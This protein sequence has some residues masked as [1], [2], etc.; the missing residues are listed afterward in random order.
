MSLRVV[1]EQRADNLPLRERGSWAEHLTERNPEVGS[2]WEQLPDVSELE[3]R[4]YA[5]LASGTYRGHVEC[6]KGS[7][8]GELVLQ[9][10]RT[11]RI[12]TRHYNLSNRPGTFSVPYGADGQ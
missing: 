1:R 3:T 4:L 11:G 12:D 7:I 2:I 5:A 8:C 9:G 10:T 6:D